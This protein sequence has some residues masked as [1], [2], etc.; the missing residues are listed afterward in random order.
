MPKFTDS[1]GRE[2]DVALD[3]TAVGDL[4]A[5]LGLDVGS[6][7]FFE[8]VADPVRMCDVLFVLVEDQAKAAGV[9]DRDFGRGLAGDVIEAASDALYE[10]LILFSPSDR[11]E[12]LR[13]V[14]TKSKRVA[15]AMTAAIAAKAARYAAMPDETAAAEV[16]AVMAAGATSSPPAGGS[17]GSSAL[18]PAGSP[19][20]T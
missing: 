13:T 11:R 7:T 6:K 3:V 16:M 15:A 19:S 14:A 10:A 18:T 1:K 4:K 20:A 12:P 5:R 8:C 2:W 17:P 9:S